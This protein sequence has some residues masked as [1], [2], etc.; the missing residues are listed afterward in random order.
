MTTQSLIVPSDSLER[1]N[2]KLQ[3]IVEVLMKQVERSTDESGQSYAH[4]QAA[5]ALEGQVRER[6]RDL[7]LALTDLQKAHAELSISKAETDSTR[8]HMSSALE[9]IR[10]GF[11]IFDADDA[12]VMRNSRFCSFLP[13]LRNRVIAPLNFQQYLDMVSNDPILVFED[14]KGRDA[15]LK[16]R[17]DHHENRRHRDFTVE[18]QGDRWIQVSEQRTPD[19]GTAILQTDITDIV[20]LERKERDKMLDSQALL[21]RA[22]LDHLNQGVVIFDKDL[23]LVGTNEKLRAMLTPPLQLLRTGSSFDTFF[24]YLCIKLDFEDGDEIS[25]LR[26]WVMG[27]SDQPL[28][29]RLKTTRDQFYDIFARQAPDNGYVMTL[30]DITGEQSAL[31]ALHRLNETLETRVAERTNELKA[32]RDS[33]ELA[34]RSKTRFVA[35][36]SH[37]LLQPL[38][39]AKLFI[40]ALDVDKMRKREAETITRI[41]SAFSSVEYILAALLDLSKLDTEGVHFDRSDFDISALLNTLEQEFRPLAREKDISF[42]V[43]TPEVRINSDNLYFRRILQNLIANAIRYTEAGCVSVTGK[44]L[45]DKLVVE[46]ADTGPGIPAARHADIFTEFTRLENATN[47]EPSMGLGLAIVERACRL[48][49]HDLDLESEIGVGTVFRVTVPKAKGRQREAVPILNEAPEVSSLEGTV[50]LVIE[51]DN[52]AR[53]A[54]VQLLESWHLDA[55]EA[56]CAKAASV[57]LDEIELKPDVIIADLHLGAGPDGLQA[58]RDIRKKHGSLPGILITADQSDRPTRDA[59]MMG[60]P[61]VRKPVEP[62]YLR[63]ALTWLVKTADETET[64]RADYT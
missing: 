50:A 36:V 33:A 7:R 31:G 29:L 28:A 4:F 39:A 60:V 8:A 20:R 54:C 49:N 18:L 15:F 40:G 41:K 58:I 59:A 45:G 56:D 42:I 26:N 10:E 17:Q 6:T 63:S 24:D 14:P 43:S 61:I 55:L 37:D 64:T 13:E 38:N 46:V 44:D 47:A 22:T 5:I 9:A 12:L 30:T 53:L 1:Q 19:G 57:L 16:E 2:E 25:S 62:R 48:L 11:A 3:T 52:E 32:A 27:R 21:I 34:N 35:A 23:H 51:N